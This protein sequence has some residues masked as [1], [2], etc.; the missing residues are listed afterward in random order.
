[1]PIYG[2][3]DLPRYDTLYQQEKTTIRKG[4]IVREKVWQDSNGLT[5]PIQKPEESTAPFHIIL[6]FTIILFACYVCWRK[7]REE[8][9]D[10]D[11]ISLQFEKDVT[12]C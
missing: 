7:I 8:R 10:F 3:T 1:M 4:V 5:Y 12:H 2:L 6:V 9:I 11:R